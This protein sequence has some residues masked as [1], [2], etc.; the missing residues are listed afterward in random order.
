MNLNKVRV[1]IAAHYA[2]PYEGN[3]IAS[4][5]NLQKRLVSEFDAECAFVFPN[6]MSIQPWADAFISVNRVYLT[7][8][9]KRLIS[10][11]E[12]DNIIRLF[13]PDLIYTH[14][15]GYDI[16][17][18]YAMI[19]AKKN[20]RQAWH[21]HDAL[22]F[23]SNKVKAMYQLW[24]FFKHYGWPMLSPKYVKRRIPPCVIG[25]CK[26]ELE[27]IKKFRFGLSIHQTVIPNGINIS[28]IN[29]SEHERHEIFTFLAFAGRDVSKRVDLLLYA[30]EKLIKKGMKIH[31]VLVDGN[32][33]SVADTIYEN[34]PYWL[35]EIKPQEDINS[36]FALADCFVSTS[37]HE[38]FSYSIAEASIFGLPVIQS[39]IEGT[40]WNSSNPSAFTF[41][42]GN[43]DALAETMLKVMNIPVAQMAQLC[44]LT[45]NNNIRDYSL[46]SWSQKVIDFFKTL[47]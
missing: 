12:S 2:A 23:Q 21:M 19:R 1:L 10:R 40:M 31:V 9:H 13:K 39:D 46:D 35:T 4:L 8:S 27:F 17:L 24:A 30:A 7:G 22:A 15:E 37:V 29:Q 3:F 32:I 47:P 42:S 36:V 5:K 16:P 33:P 26:H 25:V 14:F 28:R 45:A 6:N 18:L 20:I 41:P 43:I 38:T 34:K 44:A 11:S